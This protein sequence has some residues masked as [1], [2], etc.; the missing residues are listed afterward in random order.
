MITNCFALTPLTKEALYHELH[1][2]LIAE[3][4][5]LTQSTASIEPP[6]HS[7]L[8]PRVL[9]DGHLKYASHQPNQDWNW[10]ALQLLG[11]LLELRPHLPDQCAV[12][13]PPHRAHYF[14]P[15][16]RHD[17]HLN[18]PQIPQPRVTIRDATQ[19]AGT[20]RSRITHE[21]EKVEPCCISMQKVWTGGSQNH[22][23]HKTTS[24][25]ICC[26]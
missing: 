26:G 15:Q 7:S 18:S 25:W 13:A 24:W 19:V 1:A 8:I 16:S 10:Q 14:K 22:I 2:G 5:T 21:R 17:E 4:R 9:R 3:A 20:I 6:R 12:Q 11:L 23:P